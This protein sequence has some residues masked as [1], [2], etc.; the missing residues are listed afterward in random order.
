[1]NIQR[2]FPSLRPRR[3]FQSVVEQLIAGLRDGTIILDKDCPE[4]AQPLFTDRMSASRDK[5]P[6]KIVVP[7]N[8]KTPV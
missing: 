8:P 4:E 7:H 1:M 3:S 2:W 5:L 6:K